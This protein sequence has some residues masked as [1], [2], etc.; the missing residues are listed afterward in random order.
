MKEVCNL[1]VESSQI[2]HGV[3]MVCLK[4]TV[5]YLTYD[6]VTV[7][8]FQQ[9]I[10]VLYQPKELLGMNKSYS[11]FGAEFPIR[12][13][14]LDTIGRTELESLQVH[15]LTEYIKKTFWHELHPR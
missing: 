1:N 8:S 9:W 14:F 12:F 6:G 15:P 13:D 7:L 10:L 11:R 2:M 3:L 5:L 4:K